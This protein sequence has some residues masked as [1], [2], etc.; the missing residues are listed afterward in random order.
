M[1]VH[2]ALRFRCSKRLR[3]AQPLDGHS[4]TH[5]QHRAI[6]STDAG[7]SS[8]WRGVADDS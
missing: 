3:L 8:I 6:V 4:M 5:V 1:L 2:V 7:I